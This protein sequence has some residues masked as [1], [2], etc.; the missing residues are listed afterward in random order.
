MVKPAMDEFL[1]RAANHPGAGILIGKRDR[2]IAAQ[3]I[4]AG[5]GRATEAWF[6]LFIINDRGR[7]VVPATEPEARICAFCG[8]SIA[9]VDLHRLAD[10][11][12]VHLACAHRGSRKP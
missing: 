12:A 8:E 11:R 2:R 5:Y 4:A 3:A 6:P 10:G 1:R 7:A 9:D